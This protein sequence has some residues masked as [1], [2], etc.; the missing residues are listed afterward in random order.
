MSEEL[1]LDQRIQLLAATDD[2]RLEFSVKSVKE[3]QSVWSL[4]NEEGFVMVE[5]DDGDCVMVWPDADF[6]AQWAVEEWDDC[7]PVEISF[8]T[9]TTLWLPSLEKDNVTLAV[10]PNIEDEG[11]L[12]TAAEM[13]ELLGI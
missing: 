8:E 9:F 12:T 7:E 11:K 13:K 1:S 4:S 3:H 5:T 2:V 10:F 6:A